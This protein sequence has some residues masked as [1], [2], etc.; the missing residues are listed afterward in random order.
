MVVTEVDVH[1]YK[2]RDYVKNSCSVE[3]PDGTPVM[4]EVWRS[5]GLSTE[6]GDR[7]TMVFDPQGTIAPTD[8]L[9]PG[10]AA[11]AAVRPAAAALLLA[12]LCCIAVVRSQP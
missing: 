8:R 4:T 5:C 9:L 12:A 3:L 7:L 1:R 11:E 2:G 6:P 10:S